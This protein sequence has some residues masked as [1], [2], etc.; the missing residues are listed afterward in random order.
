[1]KP[2]LIEHTTRISANRRSSAKD[3]WGAMDFVE[4]VEELLSGLIELLG[5]IF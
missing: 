5:V 3:G 1:M 4:G 2:E